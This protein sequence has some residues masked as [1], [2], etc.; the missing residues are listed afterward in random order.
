MKPTLLL[1]IIA[2]SFSLTACTST[3]DGQTPAKAEV[4]VSASNQRVQLTRAEILSTYPGKTLRG[5]GHSISFNADGT[6]KNDTGQSGTYTVTNDGVITL[7][8]GLGLRLAVYKQGNRY[9]HRNVDSGAGG[10]YSL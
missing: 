7:K 8:G 5:S 10:F 4:S 2:A 3:T 6:W 9:Y 1:A